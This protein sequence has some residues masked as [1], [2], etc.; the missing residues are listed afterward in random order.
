MIIDNVKNCEKYY[1]LGNR[2]EQALKFIGSTDFS[3]Y[4]AGKYNIAS[5]RIFFLV[6]EYQTKSMNDCVLESHKKYIDLQFMYSGT[7]KLGH[8]LLT[9]QVVSKKYDPESDCVLYKPEDL[10][11]IKLLKGEFAIFF[12]NDLHM[13][14]IMIEKPENVKKIVVKILI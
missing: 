8:S 1:S 13:P 5:D 3:I 9:N 7:E 10:S 4:N 14:G 6:N 12:P 11:L 2:I